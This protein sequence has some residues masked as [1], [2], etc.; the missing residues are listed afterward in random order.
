MS[1]TQRE[2]DLRNYA[3]EK[4]YKALGDVVQTSRILEQPNIEVQGILVTVLLQLSCT[5]ALHS[6]LSKEKWM[7]FCHECWEHQ[8]AAKQEIPE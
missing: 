5:L 3:L 7:R 4:L 8:A 2:L 1:L 6:N